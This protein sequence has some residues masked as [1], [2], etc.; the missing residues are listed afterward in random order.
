VL[1]RMGQTGGFSPAEHKIMP[2]LSNEQIWDAYFECDPLLEGGSPRD[3]DPRLDGAPFTLEEL[4]ALNKVNRVWTTVDNHAEP[5][6]NEPLPPSMLPGM[7]TVNFLGYHV[8]GLSI[9]QVVLASSKASTV[10]S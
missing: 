10:A 7:H 8:T 5:T 3:C 9:P 1:I 4:H 6:S 2:T